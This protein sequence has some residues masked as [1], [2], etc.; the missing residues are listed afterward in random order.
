MPAGSLAERFGG[1][2]GALEKRQ[3]PSFAST[4][5]HLCGRDMP[6]SDEQRVEGEFLGVSL[7]SP[8]L[9]TRHLQEHY[10]GL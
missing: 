5:P 7:G 8:T 10:S 6:L 9:L 4:A 3:R 2:P 1:A